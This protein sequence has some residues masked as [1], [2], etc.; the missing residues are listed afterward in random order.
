MK[1]SVSFDGLNRQTKIHNS[2]LY[3]LNWFYFGFGKDCILCWTTGQYF[4]ITA[5]FL[6][7][8]HL[9]PKFN[10]KIRLAYKYKSCIFR[11]LFLMW[12]LVF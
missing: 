5:R 1:K 7:Q 9:S 2:S 8:E 12:P 11:I 4:K 10:K 3:N 6:K